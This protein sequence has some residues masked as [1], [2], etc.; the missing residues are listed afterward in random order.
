MDFRNSP[1]NSHLLN[2]KNFISN[3][4]INDLCK[5][6]K[7]FRVFDPATTL[8]CFLYQVLTQCSS[9][10]S[11][12]HFNV[13]RSKLGM[14]LTSTNTSAFTKAKQKLSENKLLKIVQEAGKKIDKQSS[15]WK[16]KNKNVYLVDGTIINLEDTKQNKKEYP[17]TFV[18]GRQQGQPKLRLLGLFSLSSGAFLD[19]EIGKYKGKG[20]SETSMIQKMLIRI[21]PQSVLVLDRFFTCFFLQSLFLKSKRNY[22]I[23][24]RDNFVRKN[25]GRK[26]DKII[27]IKQ[28]TLSKYPSY[29][30]H[31]YPK[32]INVRLIKS[33]IKRKG[34]RTATI[35]IMTSFLD[36]KK[37][38]KLDIEKLYLE[39]WGVELDIR[40][41]KCTLEA[42]Q[43]RSK[44]PEMV[45]KELWINLLG[46]NL[47]RNINVQVA[48]YYG[49]FSPRKRSF[50]T[51]LT[52]YIEVI[53]GLGSKGIDVLIKILSKEILNAKYR[54]EP[55]AIKRRV[56]RYCYLTVAR[57]KAKYQNWGYSR[58]Q[59]RMDL[60]KVKV[61]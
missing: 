17:L 40:N 21:K 1:S 6:C 26:H 58:R 4:D 46:Y 12:V 22:V 41:L 28:P 51:T 57:N 34:F 3:K 14:N 24:G 18:K 45:R 11:L 9:K 16:W 10:S 27:K 29:K 33:S 55:R 50:K 53:N 19:G 61:A 2:L 20:Q 38:T 47:V 36:Q 39:R 15:S 49:D 25:L 23:R 13:Q 32:E 59:G 31:D 48:N 42:S 5:S 7:R 54:R 35:Y 30:G 60:L 8:Y 43:L 37:Y 52:C 56:H 44:S